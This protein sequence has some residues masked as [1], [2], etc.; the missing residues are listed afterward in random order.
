VLEARD[1]IAAL[2]RWLA[3]LGDGHTWVR[4]AVP[5]GWLPYGA[6]VRDGR[7]VACEVPGWSAGWR[8][9]LRAGDEFLGRSGQD[10]WSRTAAS[11]HAR[12]LLSGRRA[13]SA[14]VGTT[15][16]LE[17][18]TRS[19]GHLRWSEEVSA[20]P[21]PQCVDW[22]RVG[23]TLGYIRI[24]AWQ[25]A[26]DFELRLDDA[27]REMAPCRGLIVD[28]RGNGGGDLLLA[29]RFRGRFLECP[30]VVGFIRWSHPAGGLTDA[31]PIHGRPT[32]DCVP[33]RGPVRFLTDPLTYSASED[34]LLGLS[35][36]RTRRIIG[37]R[38]GGG[39]GRVR[40]LRLL[41]GWRL[42]I[43]SAQTFTDRGHRIEGQGLP[44]DREVVPDRAAGAEEDPVLAA[45]IEELGD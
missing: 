22:H 39:S 34:A 13:L 41:E 25:R 1:P 7:L 6:L 45:A 43:S 16:E 12:S 27:M 40:T 24:A 23:A 29:N 37:E 3:R 11:P 38:S 42:T 2:Q 44:V 20:S 17:A 8:A 9:G 33:W 28:L 31:E 19:H 4:P 5:W 10:W 26:A 14:P 32:D 18:Q 21:W 35:D 15:V 36:G 30:R